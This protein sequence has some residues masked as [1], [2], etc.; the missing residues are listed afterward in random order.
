L[1]NLF[2]PFIDRSLVVIE[3]GEEDFVIPFFR[4]SGYFRWRGKAFWARTY[5]TELSMVT[6]SRGVVLSQ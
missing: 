6:G 3:A 4:S 2:T 5:M 1:D